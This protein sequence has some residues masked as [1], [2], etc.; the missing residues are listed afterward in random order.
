MKATGEGVTISKYHK[1]EQGMGVTT[2]GALVTAE[3]W[4]GRGSGGSA[5]GPAAWGPRAMGHRK[6]A[7]YGGI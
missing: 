5:G 4:P 6:T 2:E 7:A 1:S 3:R